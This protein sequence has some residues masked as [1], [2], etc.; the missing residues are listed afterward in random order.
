MGGSAEPVWRRAGHEF[1]NPA[2]PGGFCFLHRQDGIGQQ[3]G[4]GV[5]RP[6]GMPMRNADGCEA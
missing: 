1:S 3:A 2:L 4:A 5:M 6:A